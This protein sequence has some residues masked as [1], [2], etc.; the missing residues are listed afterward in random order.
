M[1]DTNNLPKGNNA[2]AG[3]S[4]GA[5]TPPPIGGVSP[6]PQT[7]SSDN[8][9]SLITPGDNA[10]TGSKASGVLGMVSSASGKVADEAGTRAKSF[11]SQG[12]ERG[13]ETLT[14]ISTL[15]DDTVGQ[16]EEKLGPQYAGYARTASETLNRYADRVAQK[17]PDELVDDAR[18]LIRKSPSVAL[19]AAAV[20][21]FGLIRLV[22][23]GAEGNAGGPKSVV[24]TPKN[25][26]I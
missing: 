5:G 13:S 16:I 2:N 22:K 18:E 3:A 26:D 23:A 8:T 12:L 11:L 24:V 19:S 4:G 25:Q 7:P 6:T 10:D 9:D 17:D 1:A 15:I 20:I 21:G 14:N